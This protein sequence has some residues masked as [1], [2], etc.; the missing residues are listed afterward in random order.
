[1]I[2]RTTNNSFT[3]NEGLVREKVLVDIPQSD[4]VFF[5]LF[6]DKFDWHYNVRQNLWD[7]YI[8]TSPQNVEL[9]DDEV[10]NMVR[11]VRYGTAQGNH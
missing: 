8:K 3:T 5:K 7:E 1:M 11:T 10:I 2:T 4:M 9:S 6:A